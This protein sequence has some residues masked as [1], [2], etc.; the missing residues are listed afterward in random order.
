MVLPRTAVEQA[1]AALWS[2]VLRLAPIGIHAS[3]FEIGGHSLLATQLVGRAQEVFSVALPLRS[4][5]EH[6][7][8]ER[9][10]EYVVAQQLEQADADLLAQLLDDMDAPSGEGAREA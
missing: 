10:S 5:F 4:L 6:P 7:T 2:E 9:F 3:F 1:M 8:I